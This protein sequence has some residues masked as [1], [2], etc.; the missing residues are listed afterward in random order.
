MAI[1]CINRSKSH[2]KGCRLL[3][4]GYCVEEHGHKCAVKNKKIRCSDCGSV[5][6]KIAKDYMDGKKL[7]C[8]ECKKHGQ[9]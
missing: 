1:K 9:A 7:L 5:Y 6:Y 8:E 2:Y 3:D 4:G